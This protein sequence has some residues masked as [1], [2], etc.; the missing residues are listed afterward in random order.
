[1]SKYLYIFSFV[2]VI[3][4]DFL[5]RTMFVEG[6]SFLGNVNKVLIIA[7]CIMLLIKLLIDEHRKIE[8]YLILI[9]IPIISVI[10]YTTKTYYTLL[11][12][13]L[14]I[15]NVR[16][17]NLEKVHNSGVIPVESPQVL[18]AEI[19]SKA[20][21]VNSMLGS[22]AVSIII[23]VSTYIIAIKTR[24]EAL[25]KSFQEIRLLENSI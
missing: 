22:K 11:P 19:S 24:A 6:F 10:I 17:I 4:V 1:M 23:V 25:L 9:L 16:N 2:L 20:I 15:I 3:F 21:L 14:L 7:A 8:L 5:S 13:F 12:I 18:N